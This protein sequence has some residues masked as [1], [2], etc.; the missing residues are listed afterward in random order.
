[1]GKT[2]TGDV[3]MKPI[4]IK[5]I[6][7]STEITVESGP[8]IFKKKTTFTTSGEPIGDFYDWLKLPNKTLVPD[9]MSFQLDAWK[10]EGIK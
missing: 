5:Q 7:K 1:M 4:E 10:M 9:V 8:W 3:E 2:Q 6:G